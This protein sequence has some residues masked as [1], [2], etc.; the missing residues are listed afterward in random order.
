MED[1]VNP[2]SKILKAISAAL[3][4]PL[5]DLATDSAESR[6]TISSLREEI[7]RQNRIIDELLDKIE[8]YK[9]TLK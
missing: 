9:S 4:I 2:S 3:N 1:D 5:E 7:I 8:F 6:E